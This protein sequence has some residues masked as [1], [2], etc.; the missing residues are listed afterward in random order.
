MRLS[1]LLFLLL[2]VSACRETRR[3]TYPM[4]NN[5]HTQYKPY[6]RAYTRE[7]LQK[8]LHDE[9]AQLKEPELLRMDTLL[10]TYL[11]DHW[12]DETALFPTKAFDGV[13]FVRLPAGKPQGLKQEEVAEL[14]SILNDPLSYDWRE[15]PFTPASEVRFLRGGSVIARITFSEGFRSLESDP[16]WPQW[17]LARQ[18][19]LRPEAA[20]KVKSLFQGWGI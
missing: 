16:G 20:E 1:I 17:K 5:I 3:P 2:A 11:F 10:E 8:R 12:G 7:G 19:S 6:Y 13:S 18:G 9:R 15:Q 4:G 14:L